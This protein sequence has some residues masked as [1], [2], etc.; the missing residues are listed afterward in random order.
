ME[1]FQL[2]PETKEENKNDNNKSKD[3]ICNICK[4][5]CFIIIKDYTFL[6]YGCKNNHFTK[7]ISFQN[8]EDT[9][10]IQQGEQNNHEYEQGKYNCTKHNGE[11][12]IKYCK[13]HNKNICIKCENEHKNCE[14]IYF[15]DILPNEN[16]LDCE[17]LKEYINRLK[18]EIN[19]IINNLKYVMNNIEIYYN[20]CK[21]IINKFKNSNKRNYQILENTNQFIQF[22]SKIVNDIKNVINNEIFD[23]Y[24]NIIN[25][26]D[27]IKGTKYSNYII[28]KIEI[29]ENDI[30][31]DIKIINNIIGETYIDH[32]DITFYF[33]N[34]QINSENIEIEVDGKIIP[35]S[36]YYNFKEKGTHLLKYY[37][38]KN[39]SNLSSI[40][41]YCE[42]I[43][44]IDMTNFNTKN[45]TDMNTMFGCCK[46][47]KNVN[48]SNINTSKVKDMSYIFYCC[49]SLKKVDLS[50]FNT[51]NVEKM[52]NMFDGC[53]SLE[54]VDLSNFNTKIVKNMANM[55][56]GCKSLKKVEQIKTNDKRIIKSFD[57]CKIF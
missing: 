7:N 33:Y 54:E 30:N 24:K 19:I 5:N 42:N 17:Q 49:E 45:I 15:G 1:E 20:I 4:E 55:F 23:K 46:S 22:N 29:Q 34:D 16:Q 26:Y 40:F 27:D 47:L 14:N 2:I 8:F 12:F 43:I 21:N 32:Y 44:N 52:N 13:I 50:N 10:R 56:S 38:N 48:F 51:E 39:L 53:K 11:Q 37:I 18:N 6:L 28:T 25:I 3:I 41:R 57:D 36:L 9:Q 31:K 35:F